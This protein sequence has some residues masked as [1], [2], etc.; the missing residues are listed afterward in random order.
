MAKLI[1]KLKE[2]F[3]KDYEISCLKLEIEHLRAELDRVRK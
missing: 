1:S 2:F 3:T